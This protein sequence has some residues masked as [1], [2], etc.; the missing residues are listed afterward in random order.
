MRVT[1]R[2]PTS[3][4]AK[5]RP[6]ASVLDL[7][8]TAWQGPRAKG[9]CHTLALAWPPE[10]TR[11]DPLPWGRNRTGSPGCCPSEATVTLAPRLCAPA[12][13]PNLGL[14]T[15]APEP[16]PPWAMQDASQGRSS[17]RTRPQGPP[18]PRPPSCLPLHHRQ[19]PITAEGPPRLFSPPSIP[20]NPSVKLELTDCFS[21]EPS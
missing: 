13:A 19:R 8:T 9:G 6:G 14:R 7:G 12:A 11:S 2:I 10:N 20:H 18:P 17:S 5:L 16:A 21:V 4:A 15:E 3:Q 1:G